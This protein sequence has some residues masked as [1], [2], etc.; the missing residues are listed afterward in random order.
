MLYTGFLLQYP[1]YLYNSSNI[2]SSFSYQ[3]SHKEKLDSFLPPTPPPF[4]QLFDLSKLLSLN[5]TGLK[6]YLCK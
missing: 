4:S 2:G 6:C 5:R 1:L 3:V